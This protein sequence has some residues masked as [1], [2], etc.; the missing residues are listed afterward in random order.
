MRRP[1]TPNELY[2]EGHRPSVTR[3]G[4]YWRP[5]CGCEN[6]RCRRADDKGSP[7]TYEDARRDA[8]ANLLVA[9]H[10]RAAIGP[11]CETSEAC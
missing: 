2:G 9:Q 6:A 11:D 10:G 4:Q 5:A 7:R 8:E 3:V 1:F